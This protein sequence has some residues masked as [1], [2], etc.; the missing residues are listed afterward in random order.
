MTG[1]TP[2]SSLT[3][4]TP[5]GLQAKS[6]STIENTSVLD[7]NSETRVFDNNETV[8]SNPNVTDISYDHKHILTIM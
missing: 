3:W 8:F 4:N 5:K 7:G 6:L 1:D 2:G